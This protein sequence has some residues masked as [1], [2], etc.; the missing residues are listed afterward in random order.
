MSDLIEAKSVQNNEQDIYDIFIILLKNIKTIIGFFIF[1]L[2]VFYLFS[3]NQK[4]NFTYSIELI[5]RDT[6]ENKFEDIH[7]RI[8]KANKAINSDYALY[9]TSTIYFLDKINAAIEPIKT[10][11]EEDIL[12]NFLN[13]DLF[14]KDLRNNLK[15]QSDNDFIYLEYNSSL[16]YESVYKIIESI[17]LYSS[18]KGLSDTIIKFNDKIKYLEEEFRNEIVKY[19]MKIEDKIRKLENEIDYDINLI[20]IESNRYSLEIEKNLKIA[21]DLGLEKTLDISDLNS[22]E[23]AENNSSSNTDKY[24]LQAVPRNEFFLGESILEKKLNYENLYSKK[25]ATKELNDKFAEIK[26]LKRL[27]ENKYFDNYSIRKHDID[28]LKKLSKQISLN[29]E[30]LREG[31]GPFFLYDMSSLEANSNNIS[32]L[33]FLIIFVFF[34][35]ATACIFIISRENYKNKISLNL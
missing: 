14:I 3:I 12:N 11:V 16:K 9:L 24:R 5:K 30:Y 13:Y 7:L 20:L 35:L 32:K 15:I 34:G 4:Q 17:I 10:S 26:H 19:Q 23:A 28:S 22:F 29:S 21:K 33:R 18:N 2:V 31:Q 27:Q 6:V 8:L 25:L 1:S